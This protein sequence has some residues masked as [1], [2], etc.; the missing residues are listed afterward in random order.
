MI[1]PDWCE[2]R[3]EEEGYLGGLWYPCQGMDCPGLLPVLRQ[4][5]KNMFSIK[6]TLINGSRRVSKWIFN[7]SRDRKQI[8][9]H[10][11]PPTNQSDPDVFVCSLTSDPS[12]L[13]NR[14]QNGR[15]DDEHG[16][17]RH[18]RAQHRRL[19]LLLEQLGQCLHLPDVYRITFLGLLRLKPQVEKI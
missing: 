16:L 19:H 18:P 14:P 9:T 4:R 1:C 2:H 3:S 15:D 11:S 10:V 12:G 8:K 7:L 13:Q 17:L 5:G 6:D